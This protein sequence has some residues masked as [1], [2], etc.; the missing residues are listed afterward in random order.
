MAKTK[1]DDEQ[2]TLNGRVIHA[3]P[4][5][6]S[7]KSPKK[8]ISK[9]DLEKANKSL[10]GTS[11]LNEEEQKREA[12][13]DKKPKVV[14]KEAIINPD[15]TVLG[16]ENFVDFEVEKPKPKAKKAVTKKPKV[17]KKPKKTAAKKD[18]SKLKVITREALKKANLADDKSTTVIAE[19][20][21][22]VPTTKKKVVK[23]PAAKKTAAKPKVVKKPAAKKT[24]KK[25]KTECKLIRLS[26]KETVVISKDGFVVGKSKYSDY[27]VTKNNTISRSHAIIHILDDGTFTI[28]DNDSKNGTCVDGVYL[29]AHEQ[30]EIKDDQTIKLSDEV[31]R[32]KIKG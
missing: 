28:E 17:V 9:A 10:S 25:K 15:T 27:Q 8:V 22:E 26:N 23:K 19:N 13:K 18:E 14:A 5:S 20:T 11:I 4:S 2:M 32:V 12:A 21:T 1:K 3:R 16:N 31:F 6:V 24:T 7:K 29:K 30:I